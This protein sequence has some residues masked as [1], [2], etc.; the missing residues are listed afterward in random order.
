MLKYLKK[1]MMSLK[2]LNLMVFNNIQLDLLK[3]E[4]HKKIDIK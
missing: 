1:M 3:T 4:E 2:N